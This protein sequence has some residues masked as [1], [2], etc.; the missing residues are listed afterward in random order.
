M[1]ALAR[2]LRFAFR[3]F[4]KSP[5]LTVVAVVSLAI[6]IGAN[7]A[8]FS[9]VS[10]LL[11]RPLP[12]QNADRLVILW[13]T[14]PGLGIT[15]DWFSTAQYFDIK[16][17]HKGLEQV[18]IAIGGNYN[19]TGQG[20]PL[21]VGVVRV[22][23]NLLPML[24]LKPAQ[25]RIFT[26]D[27]DSVGRPATAVLSYGLWAREFGSDPRAIGRVIALNGQPYEVV[28]IMPQSFA[29]PREVLPT[30]GLAEQAEV[31]LP[32]PLTPD[33]AQVRGHEDYNIVGKLRPG[34]TLDQARAE[35][36]T[37][38]ARLRHDFPEVY[39]GNGGLTF[40][41]TPLLEQ[42]V[43]GVRQTL[44]LLLGA[45]GFVLL[46]ACANVANLL[47]SRAVARQR[48]I[49]VRTAVGASAGRIVR[50]LLTESVVLAV[51]GGA[52]GV[53][54]A[55]ASVRWI[56][57]LGLRS[58]PR[59][60]E[61]GV[62]GDALGLTLLVSVCSG[63]LFGLAPAFRVT[64]V[65]V[66]AM[67][68]DASRGSSGGRGNNLR[69]L[70]VVS[71]LALSVMLLIAAGLLLRSFARLQR[72]SPGFNPA[73]VL[74][75]ELTMTGDQYTDPQQ[76][77]QVY[78]RL[79]EE[80]EHLPGVTAA[81]GVSSLPLSEM[82]AWGPI[83]VEG[84]VP[85]PGEKFINADERLVGGDY[86]QAMQIPL[87]QGRLFNEQDTV[88]SP[89][90]VLVDD[91]MATQLWP[92]QDPLGKR[93]SFG[94]LT[95][96]PVWATVVGVVGRIKQYALDADSRIALY[97]PQSQHTG[98]AMNV[99]LRSESS[100]PAALT[101][102]VKSKLHELDRNLPMYGARTM[103]E[104]VQE[105]L[106]RRRFSMLTLGLFAA[107]ALALATIGIYGVMSYL[108]NQGTREIGIRMALGA[109]RN[110]IAGFVM[111]RGLALTLAGA[112]IG[113]L[114]AFLITRLMSSLLFG[115]SATDP[116]TFLGVAILLS[117]VALVATY[118]PAKRA[119]RIDPIIL[120][121]CE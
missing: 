109:T 9:I 105:S 99:V 43:G 16:T 118:V 78:R 1:L 35:M 6:G 66:Q 101:Q 57:V 67:L 92:G 49:A 84:R 79:W 61:I 26:A 111:M 39:P 28:G 119:A 24:G 2:D 86:F 10:A 14:S 102:A 8:I 56:Q 83:T 74:T 25:G 38:T 85:P 77:R 55:M 73:N 53:L 65:D 58:V 27:E 116:L 106:A 62:R 95:Q 48:E 5:G 22:S 33:A 59:L 40:A 47:L 120:L 13:N 121:R 72:V 63:V 52:L 50:Q 100:D 34:V 41:I 71:E 68:Q 113:L 54:L 29:L 37:I 117:A 4:L 82:F 7:T 88:T 31:L 44:F 98:R 112:G 19:L 18:A 104:R 30:L 45:V 42:V 91:Y 93:V 70:L 23:S 69:Q 76:V 97:L 64:R 115:V 94:D 20:D 17:G 103:Q 15:Q 81:G 32:L 96:K 107:L 114:G 3:S 75:L 108:V 51:C 80:L 87:L 89:Q 21:R 90:V 36:A 12:Y 11:L 110:G 60:G 46:I